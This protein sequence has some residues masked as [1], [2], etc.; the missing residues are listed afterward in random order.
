MRM[1][2]V[3]NWALFLAIVVAS[4]SALEKDPVSIT[5]KK[6]S[7]LSTDEK[8]DPTLKKRKSL[9]VREQKKEDPTLSAGGKKDST[10]KKLNTNPGLRP[11]PTKP[12]SPITTTEPAMAALI[13]RTLDRYA[14]DVRDKTEIDRR[15]EKALSA[16]PS[17]RK[18]AQRLI[19]NFRHASLTK[20]KTVLG[21]WSD[22]SGTTAV[23]E[24]EYR[25][26]FG[27]KKKLRV[28]SGNEKVK[29]LERSKLGP[30]HTKSQSP[31]D[32][33]VDEKPSSD[34]D[35]SLVPSNEL[36][37]YMQLASGA[38][39]R[40]QIEVGLGDHPLV[41]SDELPRYAQ[42]DLRYQLYYNGMWCHYETDEDAWLDGDSDSDEIYIII[43]VVDEN[44]NT[45]TT[46]RPTRHDPPYYWDVDTGEY[47]PKS[48]DRVSRIWGGVNGRTP[49]DLLV[50]VEVWD[51]DD[52]NPEDTA[53]AVRLAWA[54]AGAIASATVEHNPLIAVIALGAAGV[55]EAIVDLMGHRD[56]L[57]EA[58]NVTVTAQQMADWVQSGMRT[59]R[60]EDRPAHFRTIHNG[61][62][63]SEGADYHVY[64]AFHTPLALE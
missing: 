7:P 21:E 56:D 9:K 38:E 29:E 43:T 35:R 52:G 36:P 41:L 15:V 33:D 61:S 2:A 48:A 58:K 57:I 24:E 53:E 45:T 37:R 62:G 34:D 6:D 10:T 13:L 31:N 60:R 23:S 25:K 14:E 1:S 26:V 39:A 40:Y 63:N 49:R 64:F 11:E 18:T 59:W 19:K 16:N 5:Q 46:K 47:R 12:K 30:K 32:E 44:G 8:K 51:R 4:S 20:R 54:T 50:S 55:V 22:I 42:A 3:V 28:D 27:G 17:N